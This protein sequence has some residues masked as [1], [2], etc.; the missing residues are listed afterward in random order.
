[1]SFVKKIVCVSK[2]K[3]KSDS[4]ENI[5]AFILS[6][7]FAFIFS[8]QSPVHLWVGSDVNIDSGVFKTISMMMRK[9]FMPYKDSFDHKGPLLYI[10]NWLGDQIAEY[11][12]IW[13]VELLFLT[14]TFYMIYKIARL[15][16][17]T[18]PSFI[19]AATAI[20]L[21]F[22]YFEEGNLTEEYAMPLIAISTY[23]FLDYFKNNKINH[24]RLFLCGVT[25]AGTFLLRPNMIAL[26][27]IMCLAVLL[28][29]K[30]QKELKEA[31]RFIIF[32]L[33]GAAVVFL[34]IA[35]WLWVNDALKQCIADFI[36]FN[37]EYTSAA[38]NA[39]RATW[40]NKWT[41]LFFFLNSTVV[42]TAFLSQIYTCKK[43]KTL[44]D[45][46]YLIYMF[47]TLIFICLAGMQYGHY[48]MVLI[49]MVV[50]PLSNIFGS[51][52]KIEN[53]TTAEMIGFVVGIYAL[54]VMVLPKW[55]QLIQGT[56]AI[57][58]ARTNYNI[59][60]EVQNIVSE[61]DRLKLGA[62]EPISVY[63]NWDIIYVISKRP[64]ATRYSYQ[65][66]IGEVKPEIMEEYM[67]ELATELPKV[68]VVQPGR[69]DDRVKAF[70]QEN[71]YTFIY[72]QNGEIEAGGAL[73]FYRG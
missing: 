27:F 20:S 58:T 41:A 31:V 7:F 15:S 16:C 8:L 26:W 23:I 73:L 62:N 71:G 6:F 61:I 55:L 5:A 66:P 39:G 38:A 59:S 34:P 36:I 54:S 64:H 33:L 21:L 53:E 60:A 12:G 72:G 2:M 24:I 35:I 18:V 30:L 49:P 11:K 19:A 25:F 50:Y 4:F 43:T 56:P 46:S 51:I 29:T 65:F 22:I 57:Y 17:R 44:C 40:A 13:L 32:F 63:G 68:I 47:V 67:K 10:L 48:G 37:K 28:K 45:Y 9:G 42:I 3:E 69:Y 14:V 70:V 1:M 52:G